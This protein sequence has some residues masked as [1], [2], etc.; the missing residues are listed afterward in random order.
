MKWWPWRRNHR[1]DHAQREL[2]E[3]RQ[4]TGR[5]DDKVARLERQAEG[6]QF[7]ARFRIALGGD[8]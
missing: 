8:R 1:L 6:N 4:S 3:A 7:A 2:H 5:I